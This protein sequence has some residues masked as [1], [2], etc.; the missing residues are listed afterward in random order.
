MDESKPAALPKEFYGREPNVAEQALQ[1]YPY[2][3]NKDVSFSFARDATSKGMLEAWPKGEIGG[4]TSKRP[5]DIPID[6]FGI[7]I[8]SPETRPIDVLGDYVSHYAVQNDPVLKQLYST[9]SDLV[10]D[11]TLKERYLWY[12]QN[13]GE[14]RPFEAWK[15]NSGL[16]EYFRGYV[17]D[18]WND[19]SKMYTPEQLQVLNAVK[20]YL[21]LA[22]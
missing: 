3:K 13:A 20:M 1:Q 4:E 17:F 14:S 7:Q 22:Q 12:Q 19:A 2:L 9:F 21:G 6:K 18:Q 15:S 5:P 8:I 16:P 10:P 11:E